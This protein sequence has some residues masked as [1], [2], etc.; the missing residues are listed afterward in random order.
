ME[1]IKLVNFV[2]REVKE[3]RGKSLD[4]STKSA[5][6]DDC[7]LQPVLEDDALLYSLEDIIEVDVDQDP[8]STASKSVTSGFEEG[9]AADIKITELHQTLLRFQHAA[10][11][12]QQRLELAEEA[13]SASRDVDTEKVYAAPSKSDTSAARPKYEGNYDG[14][15]EQTYYPGAILLL[16]VIAELH[17]TMIADKVRTETY[18]NFILHNPY[19]FKDKVVLDVGCGSSIL[20]IF[21]DYAGAKVVYAVDKY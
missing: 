1:T 12:T 4:M 13:L 17:R 20:S 19:L 9:S 2:R 11:A 14:P 10:L 3:G 21:C 8:E 6:D 16:T 5:F 7:Y 15:G 18:R